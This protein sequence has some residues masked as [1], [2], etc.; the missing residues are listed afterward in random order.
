[1]AST[2]TLDG[3]R[4]PVQVELN[5]EITKEQLLN[6]PAFRNWKDTLQTNLEL[7]YTNANHAFHQDPYVLSKIEVQSVD[8]FGPSKIGFVKIKEIGRAHV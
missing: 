3:F 2:F 1:M 4:S 7:Q 8:W 5:K 6:F